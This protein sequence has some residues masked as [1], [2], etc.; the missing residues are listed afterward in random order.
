MVTINDPIAGVTVTL[1][2]MLKAAHQLPAPGSMGIAMT[3]MRA[4]IEAKMAAEKQAR[5]TE[6]TATYF[7]RAPAPSTKHD[8]LGEETMEGVRVKGTRETSTIEAGAMGNEKP[9]TIVSERWYSPELEVEVKS[10]HNDPRMGQTTHTVTNINRTEPD[11]A[12]FA[13]PDDYKKDDGKP[14]VI[15][16]FDYHPNQ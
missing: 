9:I 5:R 16:R 14:G 15:Q 2:P 7:R 8:D 12:L 10:V 11:P 1:D 4:E 13:I 3:K 6:T